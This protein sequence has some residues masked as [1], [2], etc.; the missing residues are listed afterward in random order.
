MV[1]PRQQLGTGMSSAWVPSM[2]DCTLWKGGWGQ[3]HHH[4]LLPAQ[5]ADAV[6]RWEG[7]LLQGPRLVRKVDRASIPQQES[8]SADVHEPPHARLFC[9]SQQVLRS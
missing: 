2:P 4:G 7:R 1:A 9:G 6:G 3:R 8:L 5:F